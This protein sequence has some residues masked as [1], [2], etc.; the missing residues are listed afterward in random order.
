MDTVMDWGLYIDG[1][2]RPKVSFDAACDQAEA[3]GG[4]VWIGVHA[5]NMR[6]LSQLGDVLGLHPLA[7]EDA[8]NK[9]QRSKLVRYST[10]LFVSMRTLAYLERDARDEGGDVVETGSI[11]VLIGERF[12]LTIRHGRHASMS[13]LARRLDADPWHLARGPS[14]VLHVVADMVVDDYLAVVDAV[15]EDIEEIEAAVFARRAPS[16]IERIYQLKRD[17]LEMRHVVAALAGATWQLAVRPRRLVHP[18]VREYFR[19]VCDHLDRV[20]EQV[21]SFDEL[22]SSILEAGL[23]RLS[24]SENEDMRRISAWVAIAAVPT[25]IAAIYGMNF[26]YMPELTQ[27]WGYPA[28]VVAMVLICGAL[29]RGFQCNGWL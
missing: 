7:I 18:D 19:D 5:P 10:A 21:Q 12:A 1:V 4:F 16:D 8:A 27:T 26:R 17:V 11:M 20:R 22:L 9:E 13:D 15:T 23:A 25:M 29:Y 2:R 28:T 6:Q 24:V 3:E 14:A